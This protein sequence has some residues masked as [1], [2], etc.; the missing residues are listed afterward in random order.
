MTDIPIY[1]FDGF[2]FNVKIP[3]TEITRPTIKNILNYY[4]DSEEDYEE[5]L[6]P[7]RTQYLAAR[8]SGIYVARIFYRRSD[9]THWALDFIEKNFFEND[10][11]NRKDD[12]IYFVTQYDKP[13]ELEHYFYYTTEKGRGLSI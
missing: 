10:I 4:F 3:T 6:I 9:D 7:I 11:K 1:G 13:I 8:R 12:E 5:Q 2:L